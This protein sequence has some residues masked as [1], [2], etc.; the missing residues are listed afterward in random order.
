MKDKLLIVFVK[1]VILGKAKTRLAASIGKYEAFKVYK[2][3]VEIT[4]IETSKL[5]GTDIH[6]YFSDKVIQSKWPGEKKFVQMGSDLGE[7]MKSAFENGFNEGYTKI[8]GIGSDLPNI[9]AEIIEKGLSELDQSD[10]V[11]G[12]AE[13]GGYYLLG[14]KKMHTEIFDG[15]AWSTEGLLD[16]TIKALESADISYKKIKTLNDVDN[17]EDLANSSLADEFSYLL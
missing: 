1:N 5:V 3:L 13:D 16:Q 10:T 7:R 14:M 9:T 2:R 4:E 8:V 12:P 15:K 6:I 17:I 11:F